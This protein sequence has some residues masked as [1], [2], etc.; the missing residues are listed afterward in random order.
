MLVYLAVSYLRICRRVRG[1]ELF[2][3]NICISENTASPFV[4]GVIKPRIC[5]PERMDAV[6]MSYVISH[7]EAHI[8]RKD[9]WWKLLGFLLLTMHW[10]NPVM[11]LSYIL[12][13]RDIELACD[14]HVVK[15]FSAVQRADYSE[16]LLECSVK[17]SMMFVCPLAFGEVGV[18]QRIRSVLNDKKPVGVEL[19]PT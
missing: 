3:D 13:C 1:A 9:H 15:D 18:K 2:R 19:K 6:S 7:E 17:R 5:L 16:A 4:I 10:F 11:W 8:R 12:F 14:E